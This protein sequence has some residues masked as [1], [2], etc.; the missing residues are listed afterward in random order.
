MNRFISLSTLVITLVI[1]VSPPG[2]SQSKGPVIIEGPHETTQDSAAK[3]YDSEKSKITNF[4]R[5]EMRSIS[6]HYRA[7]EAVIRYGA[8]FKE[9][10]NSHISALSELANRVPQVFVSG[11]EMSPDGWGAKTSVW[12]DPTMFRKHYRSFQQ[13]ISNLVVT[14]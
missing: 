14:I 13:S 3:N 2:Y 8:P 9:N 4:R 1:A 6:G 11:T 10:L 12:S 5:Q 7:L